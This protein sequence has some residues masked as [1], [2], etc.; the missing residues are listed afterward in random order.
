MTTDTL[1]AKELLASIDGAASAFIQ[2]IA[3]LT[4]EQI[5]TV[6]FKDSWTAGQ[7]TEH[8]VKS[9]TG[10]AKALNIEGSFAERDPG[11]REQ[12]LKEMFLDF[13]IK[14]QSPEFILPTKNS[15]S[16]EAVIADMKR[17]VERLKEES[18]K[19]NLSEAINHPAFGE[20]TKLELLHF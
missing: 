19:T 16:R 18:K 2:L 17:S 3:S 12:E 20:I 5:N 13:T 14:F 1:P 11:E 7:L 6:P 15:Y 9:N 8:V 4:K 10:I